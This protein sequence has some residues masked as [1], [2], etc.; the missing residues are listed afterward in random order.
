MCQN[1][2]KLHDKIEEL[3][4]QLEQEKEWKKGNYEAYQE[5]KKRF[6]KLAVAYC[7]EVEVAGPFD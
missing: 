5:L 2:R 4:S 1:C 3:Q 7:Y 6:E